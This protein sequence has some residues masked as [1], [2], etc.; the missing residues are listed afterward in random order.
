MIPHILP[1]VS[2]GSRPPI[3]GWFQASFQAGYMTFFNSA[4]NST[5]DSSGNVYAIFNYQ[6]NGV[7]PSVGGHY[8]RN[9]TSLIK[10][11]S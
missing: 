7:Q 10:T 2:G 5:L 9:I 11:N 8:S 1:M 4:T 6:H 3:E